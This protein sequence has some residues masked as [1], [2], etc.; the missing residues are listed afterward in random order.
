M[1]AAIGRL[2]RKMTR[3]LETSTSQPPR[4][5]PTM[6]EIPVQDV[7]CPI[8]LPRAVPL[9]VAVIMASEA[10]VRSA[11]A[12]PWTARKTMSAGAVRGDRAEQ[13]GGGEGRD[14][15]REDPRLP[16][17][18]AERAA[19][20][21]QRAE[22]E[23]VG[24]DDPLLRREP[25]AEVGLDRRQRD[26]DDRAVDEGHRRA[27]DARDERPARQAGIQRQR[28]AVRPL[29]PAILRAAAE[30]AAGGHHGP[31]AAYGGS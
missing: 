21:D 19:D 11:P 7:H 18:V 1:T 15:D 27:E 3:Q 14:P 30:P 22:G 13:G 23:Q 2:S 9:K 20:E 28:R 26:V 6:N 10:G 17:D 24:V 12:M 16:E 8:A 31:P 29:H 5:G 4:V 25:A